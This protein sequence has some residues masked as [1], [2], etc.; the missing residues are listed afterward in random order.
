MRANRKR[1]SELS[2]LQRQKANAR[3][4]ANVALNRGQIDR[5][6]CE[7]CESEEAQMHHEDY[8]KPLDVRWLCRRC[9]LA[10]HR[11]FQGHRESEKPAN[12]VG[13]VQEK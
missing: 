4:Y 7:V 6:P 1:Y 13:I 5:E 8:S 9:H 11:E 10:E 2:E 3:S 12:D